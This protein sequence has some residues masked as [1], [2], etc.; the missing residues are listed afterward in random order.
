MK[1]LITFLFILLTL[2]ACGNHHHRNHFSINEVI[3]LTLTLPYTDFIGSGVN[4][5]K[6]N[7]EQGNTYC[8]YTFNLSSN[9]DTVLKLFKEDGVLI[10]ESDNV[11]SDDLSS[12]IKITILETG[13]YCIIVSPKDND[14]GMYDI[15][16]E[17]V[18]DDGDNSGEDNSGDDLGED[19]LPPG[20]VGP[21]RDKPECNPGK[22][23]N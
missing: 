18:E 4:T 22:G 1:Q 6:I 14:T 21:P 16:V 13:T 10:A 12:K 17:L 3:T 8:I 20:Q 2:S 19:C 5:Y 15:I 7:L 23:P 11:S 9:I